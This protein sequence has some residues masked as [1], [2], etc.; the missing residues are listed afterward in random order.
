[1][2]KLDFFGPGTE[3]EHV[4]LVVKSIRDV[5]GDKAEIYS[6]DIQKVFVAFV[7]MHGIRVELI[8][9][10]GEDSPVAMNLKKGQKLAHLCY[11]VPDIREAVRIGRENG[12]HCIAKPVPAAAFG[13]RPIAWLFSKTYGLVELVEK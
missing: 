1:M 4:G 5:S 7:D 2:I 11:S 8:Q 6:D 13:E 12:Y 10:K 9:P 3:F